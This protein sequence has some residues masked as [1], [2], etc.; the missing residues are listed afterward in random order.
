MWHGA[1]RSFEAAE[2]AARYGDGFFVNNLFA[3]IEYFRP[4][5]ELYRSRFAEHGHGGRE[6]AV[7]GVGGGLWVRLNS[8][9][10][11]RE[12]EP[13]FRNSPLGSGGQRLRDVV[14][15]TGLLIGSPAEIIERVARFRAAF[16]DYQRQLFGLDWAGV[17]E[18]AVHEVLD[19]AGEHLLPAVRKELAL[20]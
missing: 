3:P 15:K 7:V 14:E 2:T 8:Q 12:Y 18:T 9:D 4:F 6:D 19:L 20:T 11:Y 16:G 10:A 17:P 5:V 13:Y 1:T